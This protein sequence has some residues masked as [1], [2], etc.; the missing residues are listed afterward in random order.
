[1]TPLSRVRVAVCAWRQYLGLRHCGLNFH[2]GGALLGALE[3][4]RHILFVQVE[5][6]TIGSSQMRRIADLLQRNR[7]VIPDDE[8][9]A[10]SYARPNTGAHNPKAKRP[11]RSYRNAADTKCVQRRRCV[12]LYT[13][14]GRLKCSS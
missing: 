3:A 14:A 12:V 9:L 4:N 5:H 1:M 8:V 13:A 7:C 10:A 6:N 2:V 11:A